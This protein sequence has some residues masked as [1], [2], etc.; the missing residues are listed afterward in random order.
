VYIPGDSPSVWSI[1]PSANRLSMGT[2]R[3][4]LYMEGHTDH[5]RINPDDTW[6]AV[7]P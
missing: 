2:F 4:R 6:V 1:A 7:F 3:R 5:I